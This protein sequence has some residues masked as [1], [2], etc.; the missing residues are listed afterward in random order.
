[1]SLPNKKGVKVQRTRSTLVVS[2][3]C[4][5]FT[6]FDWFNIAKLSHIGFEYPTGLSRALYLVTLRSE[7]LILL[8]TSFGI[9]CSN[10]T[11]FP[12]LE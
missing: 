1:M 10:L 4:F 7:G 12:A 11:H 5:G 2:E 6:V 8:C 3:L 9:G